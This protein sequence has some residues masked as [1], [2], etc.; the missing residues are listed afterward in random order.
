[1]DYQVKKHYFHSAASGLTEDCYNPIEGEFGQ[2]FVSMS[3][4][5]C[6]TLA[7][8]PETQTGKCSV[9]VKQSIK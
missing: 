9:I 4:T 5:Y 8:Y 1:M 6:E 2:K 7:V 3:D